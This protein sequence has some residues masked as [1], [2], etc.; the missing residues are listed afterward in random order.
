MHST[1]SFRFLE[2][3]PTGISG[4]HHHHHHIPGTATG[5]GNYKIFEDH[6]SNK[7]FKLD[8]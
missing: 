3:Y 6:I 7:V 4:Y 5:Y 2:K 8:S 1:L